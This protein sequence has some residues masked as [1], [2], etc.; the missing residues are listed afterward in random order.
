MRV[1][2]IIVH[3]SEG[4]MQTQWPNSLPVVQLRFAR[5]TVQIER[6]VEFYHH[7]VGLPILYSYMD[8][9]DYDG[10]ML[11][12]PGRECHL[13]ISQHRGDGPCP[14]PQPDNLLVFYIP[15]RCAIQAAVAR[16]REMGYMPVA[17]R[18]PYWAEQGVTIRDPD[19]W[20]IVLMNTPGFG[21][22]I[23]ETLHY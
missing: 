3:R 12:L 23:D 1:R 10:V 4:D 22:D 9:T 7:G 16:L 21:D 6:I 18:N 2:A 8:D 17:P 14:V 5:P 19:G 11:G 20:H 15:D 13:E